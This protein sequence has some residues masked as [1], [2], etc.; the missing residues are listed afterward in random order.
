M[1]DATAPAA[2]V[3]QPPPLRRGTKIAL[4]LV[5]GLGWAIALS[6]LIWAALYHANPAVRGTLV[7]YEV[8]SDRSVAVRYEI[9]RKAGVTAECV[10]RSRAADGSE[11]GR[12]LIVIPP[13]PDRRIARTEVLTTTGRAITGEIRECR[14]AAGR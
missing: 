13:G 9:V 12:R 11:V 8:T 14:A 5:L 10:I 2:A 1:S 4:V 3:H 6:W 7:G